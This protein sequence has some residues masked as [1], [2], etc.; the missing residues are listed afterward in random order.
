MSFPPLS[1]I[2]PRYLVYDFDIEENGV[3]LLVNKKDLLVK[4][5]KLLVSLARRAILYPL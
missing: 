1:P 2:L 4:W 3:G 5:K